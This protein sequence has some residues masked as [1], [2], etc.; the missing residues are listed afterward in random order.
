MMSTKWQTTMTKNKRWKINDRGIQKLPENLRKCL[1]E[2]REEVIDPEELTKAL[3]TVC[4]MTFRRINNN[5][6]NKGKYW[7]NEDIALK[8]KELNKTRRKLTR[9]NKKAH[10]KKDVNAE[11]NME[12]LYKT[13]KEKETT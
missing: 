7:W 1:L 5:G 6:R 13:Y 2:G 9:Q 4:D 11:G 10:R 12:T 8:R 3:Q